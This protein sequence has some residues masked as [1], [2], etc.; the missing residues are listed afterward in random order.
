MR[1]LLILV[2]LVVAGSA[3][4]RASDPVDPAP[5]SLV[6]TRAFDHRGYVTHVYKQCGESPGPVGYVAHWGCQY[7]VWFASPPDTVADAGVVAG[8]STPV[9]VGTQGSFYMSAAS[10]IA[11]GNTIEI[12]N[13]WTTAYGAVNCP[14]GTPCYMATQ[15][16]IVQ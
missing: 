3:G 5:A 2:G 11:A 1:H 12:W 14:P 4:C 10:D 8:D 13:D 9:F 6:L 7:N 15:I 16:V